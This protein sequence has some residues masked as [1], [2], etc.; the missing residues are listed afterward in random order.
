MSL[1]FVI[2]FLTGYNLDSLT[3]NPEKYE[4]FNASI[5]P[6]DMN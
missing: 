2:I 1:C 3:T 6:F 5:I 4:S